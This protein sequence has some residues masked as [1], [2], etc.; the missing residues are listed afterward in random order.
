[1]TESEFQ[2]GPG[3]FRQRGFIAAAAVLALLVLVGVVI[4][5]LTVLDDDSPAAREPV[6]PS[7]SAEPTE[8]STDPDASRCGLSGLEKSGTLTEP[9]ADVTWELVGTIALPSTVGS[10]PGEAS[11]SGVR[12]CY[13]HTPTGALLMAANIFAWNKA[14]DPESVLATS[15]ASGPGHDA[16]RALLRE[17]SSGNAEDTSRFQI[18]GFRLLSY[19]GAAAVV[20]LVLQGSDGQL[21]SM[22]I[23]LAWEGG[24]WRLR[25]TASGTLFN[26]QSLPD[27]TGY[28]PWSGA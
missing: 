14:A 19:T 17:Q 5:V 9:P 20:D 15:I 8:T 4:T 23:E 3:P 13:A 18:S 27:L 16:A 7:S 24:D 1:M 10:G 2:E 11:K 6:S 26:G 25:L 21:V 22:P 28:F 12:Y